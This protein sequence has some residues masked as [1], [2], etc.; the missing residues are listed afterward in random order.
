[1]KSI[2]IPLVLFFPLMGSCGKK[3]PDEKPPNIILILADDLGYGD[4]DCYGNSMNDTPNLDQMAREGLR[5]TDFH[6]N[7]PVCS[8]TRAALLSGKYQQ[9]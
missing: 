4:L 6:S 3:A 7:C 9:K 1:M 8:P 5:F 2:V